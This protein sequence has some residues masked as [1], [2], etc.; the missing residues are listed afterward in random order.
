MDKVEFLDALNEHLTKL[1]GEHGLL[2]SAHVVE[3]QPSDVS[4]GGTRVEV[5]V[6][7]LRGKAPLNSS[8]SVTLRHFA[9]AGEAG[10]HMFDDFLKESI[11]KLSSH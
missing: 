1:A 2:A 7:N 10:V 5:T 3:R 9:Q 4:S 8:T 11:R 6:S